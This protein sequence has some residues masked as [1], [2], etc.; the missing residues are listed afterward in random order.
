MRANP[1]NL[2]VKEIRDR[3]ICGLVHAGCLEAATSAK[4]LQTLV[5]GAREHIYDVFTGQAT[6]DMEPPLREEETI[7]WESN[8]SKTDT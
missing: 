3:G 7:T 6:K 4:L 1:G 8:K 2:I 5:F